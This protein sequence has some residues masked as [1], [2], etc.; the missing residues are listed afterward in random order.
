MSHTPSK[1]LSLGKW[2]RLQQATNAQGTFTI[3]AID[4]R[5]PL[6]RSLAKL[7]P[8][9]E[10]DRAVIA[11]KQ[12]IVRHLA[13]EASAVLLDPELGLRP[14]IVDHALPGGTGLL[15]AL[16]TGS[17]GD[18]AE[19]KTGLVPGWSASK[20]VAAGAAGVKL[21]VYFHPDAAD[22][23]EVEARVQAIG[24]ACAEAEI[25]F[26]L[27]P[28]SKSPAHPG[29]PL[30]SSLHLKV[31]LETARRLVPLGV[32]V[33][34][35]EFPV[36]ATEEPDLNVWRAACA[37]LARVCP[38]PWVLLSGGV[39]FDTFLHQTAIACEAGASGVIAGRAVW[40]EA[41]TEENSSRAQF[42]QNVARERMQRLRAQ[43]EAAKPFTDC[44]QPSEF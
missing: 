21:L 18:P 12:D 16:D 1:T 38:I 30:D 3:L 7:L 33:L 20:A 27:E 28:L 10:T 32:D 25:P 11:L 22:A 9:D 2:R 41:V 4:H 36:N 40:N 24:L 8:T 34:K 43:C 39:P 5:G 35:A 19:L 15:I 17:T 44:F 13:P 29:K 31:I 23:P 42:L 14:C 37:E 6:R 26:Y